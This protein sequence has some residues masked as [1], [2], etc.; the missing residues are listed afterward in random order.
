MSQDEEQKTADN[1]KAE[2]KSIIV[3]SGPLGKY[4][5]GTNS[6]GAVS[7]GKKIG[8]KSAGAQSEP[9]DID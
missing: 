6:P 9:T 5:V 3:V 8:I 4:E 1:D 7:N 2:Y